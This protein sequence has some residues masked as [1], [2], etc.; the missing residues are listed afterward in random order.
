MQ[1]LAYVNKVL[2]IGSDVDHD[3]FTLEQVEANAVRCPDAA[4]A[5]KMYTGANV[6]S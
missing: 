5:K 4:A 1:I 6:T 3:S 2:E